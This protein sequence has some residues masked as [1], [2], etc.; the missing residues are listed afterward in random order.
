MIIQRKELLLHHLSGGPSGC[1]VSKNFRI[2][3][4][5]NSNLSRSWS[6]VS[7]TLAWLVALASPFA[8]LTQFLKATST[9]STPILA[10]N[11]ALALKFAQ[12][13]YHPRRIIRQREVSR[14]YCRWTDH[15]CSAAA[16][17][18]P[19]LKQWS[20]AAL[21]ES[22]I[23]HRSICIPECHIAIWFIFQEYPA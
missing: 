15:L 23:S 13:C 5:N 20:M 17:F 9:T 2:K 4:S 6:Y 19:K 8:P 18:Y 22:G 3:L 7:L 21:T 14:F 10:S 12:R 16:S 1:A 11:V